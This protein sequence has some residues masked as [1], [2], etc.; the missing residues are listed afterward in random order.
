IERAV[1]VAQQA[2]RI[3]KAGRPPSI[4]RGAGAAAA[5]NFVQLVLDRT[6]GIVFGG[7]Y[8]NRAGVVER[9]RAAE[10]NGCVKSSG[11]AEPKHLHLRLCDGHVRASARIVALW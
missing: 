11:G 4:K 8:R 2:G 5:E 9:L 1:F 7:G 6:D 10:G 3:G